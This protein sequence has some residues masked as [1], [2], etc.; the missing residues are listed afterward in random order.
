MSPKCPCHPSPITLVCMHN[1]P[2]PS[3]LTV[4]S[5]QTKWSKHRRMCSPAVHTAWEPLDVAALQGSAT[6][7]VHAW[8]HS[9]FSA[10]SVVSGALKQRGRVLSS[11][12]L[13][14]M[15]HHYIT[16]LRRWQGKQTAFSQEDLPSSVAV[17]CRMS[18]V[19]SHVVTPEKSI[20]KSLFSL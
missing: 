3:S 17:G 5:M 7:F 10:C 2:A 19:P 11:H 15:Q 13:V 14:M 4:S 1:N 16:W 6:P 18:K 9:P 20:I 12:N 8:G